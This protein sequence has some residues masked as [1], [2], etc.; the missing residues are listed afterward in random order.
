MVFVIEEFEFLCCCVKFIFCSLVFLIGANPYG[1]FFFSSS[2][3]CLINIRQ[4]YVLSVSVCS[5][6]AFQPA[7]FIVSLKN[8]TVASISS[9]VLRETFKV[10]LPLISCL[11]SSHF[12]Y[13]LSFV[14]LC[15]FFFR[16]LVQLTRKFW[17]Y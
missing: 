14:L 1:D 10:N 5:G 17:K 6:V 8:L 12:V 4:P 11:K 16:Q 2:V 7:H 13:C 15:R 9:S 3:F